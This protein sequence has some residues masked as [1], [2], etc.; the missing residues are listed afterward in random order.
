MLLGATEPSTSRASTV[1]PMGARL[2]L[3]AF[4]VIAVGCT[5]GADDRVG[6]DPTSTIDGRP[7]RYD[8]GDPPDVDRRATPSATDAFA[9]IVESL[10][11]G[12]FATAG[13]DELVVA[14]DARHAWLVS[15]LL[16]FAADPAEL[17]LLVAAFVDL[18]RRRPVRR[19]D[20]R[21]EPLE[22]R[23]GPLDRLGP[24]GAAR[25]PGDE[26]EPVHARRAALGAVLR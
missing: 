24:A 1:V 19:S 13:L 20:V 12:G 16:R 8:Y 25:L 10:A 26:V 22:V 23:H 6:D 9:G 5:S 2:G 3:L 14:G 15:D 21:R 4:A 18:T 11:I 17:E 7:A